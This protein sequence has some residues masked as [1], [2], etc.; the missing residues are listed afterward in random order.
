MDSTTAMAMRAAHPPRPG[1]LI[2]TATFLAGTGGLVLGLAAEWWGRTPAGNTAL[3]VPFAG[4]PA[5]LAAGWALLV[6]GVR[7]RETSR[8]RLAVGAG[9]SA[10]AALVTSLL[11]IFTP[12]FLTTR[13]AV[14]QAEVFWVSLVP[15]LALA[16]L[17]GGLLA[18]L[19]GHRLT[20]PGW[21]VSGA[22]AVLAGVALWAL[23]GVAYVVEALLLPLLVALPVAAGRARTPGPGTTWTGLGLALLALPLVLAAGVQLGGALVAAGAVLMR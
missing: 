2:A 16:V 9:L 15:P 7:Q 4:G 13:G 19:L 11:A 5:L 1:V 3:V 17:A 6:L 12:V 10:L 18:A 20:G 14:D 22:A 23:P 21:A 8:P